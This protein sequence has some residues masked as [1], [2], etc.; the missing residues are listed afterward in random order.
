MKQKK[1]LLTGVVYT[2]QLLVTTVLHTLAPSP[3]L[4]HSKRNT[5]LQ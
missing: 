3:L 2:W 1:M 4:P 5:M